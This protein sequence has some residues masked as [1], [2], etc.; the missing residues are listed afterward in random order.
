MKCTIY[1]NCQYKLIYFILWGIYFGLNFI[2]K[3]ILYILINFAPE[4]LFKCE[5][6]IIIAMHTKSYIN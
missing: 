3:N 5:I 4:L 1:Y 2:D 6:L